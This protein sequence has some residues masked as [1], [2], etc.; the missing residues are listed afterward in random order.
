MH[1]RLIFLHLLIGE[2]NDVEI[3]LPSTDGK[4]L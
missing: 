2:R 4:V 3:G 1:S